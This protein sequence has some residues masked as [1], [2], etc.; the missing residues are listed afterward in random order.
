M[1]DENSGKPLGGRDSLGE[2]SQRSPRP[3]S[4]WGG[5]AAPS[6]RTPLPLSAFGVGHNKN[7]EHAVDH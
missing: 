1:S 6:T 3:R 5:V 4:W 2:S 7:P